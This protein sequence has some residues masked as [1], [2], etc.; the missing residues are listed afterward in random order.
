MQP[1]HLCPCP[2]QATE[3]CEAILEGYSKSKK[4]LF[5]SGP[6]PRGALG[7]LVVQCLHCHHPQEEVGIE[8]DEDHNVAP[9]D[10]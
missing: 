6:S 9:P 8:T 2:L 1:G 10:P 4:A 5:V 3:L 7:S